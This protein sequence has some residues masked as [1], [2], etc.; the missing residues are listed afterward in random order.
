M[1]FSGVDAAC[2]RII[3]QHQEMRSGVLDLKTIMRLRAHLIRRLYGLHPGD[4]EHWIRT[5]VG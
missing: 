3:G 2:L 1:S 4:F 5:C